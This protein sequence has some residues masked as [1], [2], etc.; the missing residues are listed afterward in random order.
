M[1]Y[2]ISQQTLT[3]DFWPCLDHLKA[4]S[5]PLSPSSMSAPQNPG[6]GPEKPNDPKAISTP[7]PYD[8]STQNR[9]DTHQALVEVSTQ[10]PSDALPITEYLGSSLISL[11]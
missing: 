5:I 1:P 6:S 10:L 11:Q 7:K 3:F 2:P 9:R 8:V 4:Q